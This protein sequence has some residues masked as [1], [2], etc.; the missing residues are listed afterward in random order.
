MLEYLTGTYSAY[1]LGR[2]IYYIYNYD[3]TNKIGGDEIQ[4]L[5]TPIT[6]INI[7]K[8]IN[9][10]PSEELLYSKIFNDDISNLKYTLIDNIKYDTLYINNQNDLQ[11]ICTKYKINLANIKSSFLYPLICKLAVS[12]QITD[13]SLLYATVKSTCRFGMIKKY[14]SYSRSRLILW[15]AFV[16]RPFFTFGSIMITL[17]RM[18]VRFKFMSNTSAFFMLIFISLAKYYKNIKVLYKFIRNIYYSHC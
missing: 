2:V 5:H 14:A 17:M 13:R 6:H 15:S 11:F 16:K 9:G 18:L 4:L 3:K 1:G 10:L 12:D 8:S 7:Y